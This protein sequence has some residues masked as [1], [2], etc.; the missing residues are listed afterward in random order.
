MSDVATCP[1]ELQLRQLVDGGLAR[2]REA[3]LTQHLDTCLVCQRTLEILTEA[4]SLQHL[5]M[6]VGAT[7]ESALA[8]VM[9]QLKTPDS[10]G[11]SA[12]NPSTT[13]D[14]LD[15]L[16]PSHDPRHLG[17]FG[18]YEIL[19]V[20]G[21]G[22]MGI[23]LKAY[24]P[25]LQRTVAIKV[26]RLQLAAFEVN[27]VRFLREARAAAAVRHPHVVGIHRVA[28]ENGLPYLV[29]E[30]VDGPSLQ[31]MLERDGPLPVDEVVRIG[32][33]VA[34]GLAAAHAQGLI[35]RDVKPANLLVETATGCV[36]VTDFGLARAAHDVGLTQTGV[37]AGTPQ[38]MAPEQA[39][40]EP[41]DGRTDLF[42]LGSVLYTLTTGRP[43]FAGETAM[44]VLFNVC[45]QQ[46]TPPSKLNADIP[47][48]LT[49]FIAKLHAKSPSDRFT[50]AAEV[51]TLLRQYLAHRRQPSQVVAP[52]KPTS[53]ASVVPL[54]PLR[55]PGI[56]YR[57]RRTLWGW[58]LLHIATGVD[59]Q[60]NR[61][62]VARGVIALG[63]V[64]M[65][66]IALGG[67]AIGGIALG[68]L[69]I[70]GVAIGGGAIGLLLAL[71]GLAIGGVA[72]GGGTI[73][74]VALGGGAL[75]YYALGGLA[76]GPHPLG[77]NDQDYEAIEFF[78]RYLGS[79]IKDLRPR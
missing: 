74:L 55:P 68:G 25:T 73:G 72:V 70:G 54:M 8:R 52:P 12:P 41:L 47:E 14:A 13:V 33:E 38:Y 57:S 6:P 71:G 49:A 79:W 11:D 28:E 17:R 21:R 76:L 48:W 62:R 32:A 18:E 2:E 34:A 29:V 31:T 42:C 59:P 22:G 66:G 51:E 9:Q 75:G 35:H 64:A 77:A 26:L 20:V 1:G 7:Q 78:S 19:E 39:R 16:T 63:N 23:V 30:Y 43:P 44:A 67:I 61:M 27:R 50:S 36:K 53:P 37:I 15:F 24:D 69:A 65:G 45:Q 3:A 40:G 46:P 5:I 60:T 58:P 4:L 10:P 56:D